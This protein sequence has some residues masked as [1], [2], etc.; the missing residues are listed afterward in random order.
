MAGTSLLLACAAVVALM[1]GCG[2]APVNSAIDEAADEAASSAVAAPTASTEGTPAASVALDA[3]WQA[4]T[5]GSPLE[6][7]YLLP[8]VQAV[9]AWRVRD[10]LLQPDAE[11]LLDALGPWGDLAREEL[12]QRTGVALTQIDT[13]LCGFY[14]VEEGPPDVIWV[15]RLREPLKAATLQ[16]NWPAATADAAEPRAFR[17]GKFG[18]WL[19]AGENGR[20]LIVCPVDWLSGLVAADGAAPSL[21]RELELLREAS[22][23]QRQFTFLFAPNFLA[24]G[25]KGLLSGIAVPLR[26][27][28]DW[29]LGPF[30][31]GAM[32]S[33]QL[34]DTLFVELAVYA[35]A[36]QKPLVQERNLRR[37][38]AE[39]P[40]RASE[41]LT[42]VS[43]S[44]Y[45]RAVLERWPRM[46]DV[47]V[48][49]T[50]ADVE[51]RVVR[52][53]AYL[54]AIAAHNLA[55]AGWLALEAP[56]LGT[57]AVSDS[58]KPNDLQTLLARRISL[59]FP[60]TPLETALELFAAEAG[61]ELEIVGE[62]L[63][64]EGITKNQMLA[65]DVQQQ[66]AGQV[67]E[68]ILRLANAEGK[69]VYV[70]TSR[71]DEGDGPREM[72]VVTTRAA[73]A[74]RSESTN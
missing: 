2:H 59:S 45:N 73:A 30:P 25:G 58:A 4:P 5:A 43:L 15:L 39:L 32:L 55:L 61:V 62:D 50:R 48:D 26:D 7:D 3:F 33:L 17:A 56:T 37:R 10:F 21:R 19:P 1:E 70:I 29:L 8:G 63:R 52:L 54:P 35:S 36:D 22:D 72:I 40:T 74:R 13:L 18:Y 66:P 67:L 49:Y 6:L 24:T 46:L 11:K 71:V 64:R 27:E 38:W 9:L 34:A 57:V 53:R 12:P 69:L 20:L 28:I 60:R 65:L 51:E 44:D 16:N 23:T 68:S 41:Y 47:L 42:T 31:R 14:G